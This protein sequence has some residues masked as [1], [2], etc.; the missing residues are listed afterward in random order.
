MPPR[1][2]WSQSCNTVTGNPTATPVQPGVAVGAPPD[3]ITPD[4]AA[5]SPFN[6]MS[7][8]PSPVSMLPTAQ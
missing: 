2:A 6:F 8:V 5:P 1:A 3:S 7:M 4:T